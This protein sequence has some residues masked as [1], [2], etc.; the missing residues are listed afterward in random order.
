MALV[1]FFGGESG[2][3]LKWFPLPEIPENIKRWV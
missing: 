1:P 2:K 3:P